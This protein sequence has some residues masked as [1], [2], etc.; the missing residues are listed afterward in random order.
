MVLWRN[1]GISVRIQTKHV[2]KV[3]EKT[4]LT[5]LAVSAGY[6]FT[7]T[8]SITIRRATCFISSICG[9]RNRLFSVPTNNDFVNCTFVWNFYDTMRNVWSFLNNESRLIFRLDPFILVN[10]CLAISFLMH[11]RQGI[12]FYWLGHIHEKFVSFM[13]YFR[14]TL[15][16]AI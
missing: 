15:V 4:Q 6:I 12:H 9:L 13:K 5:S 7:F 8:L 3:V 10:L 16:T 11:L 2:L 14:S 1:Y